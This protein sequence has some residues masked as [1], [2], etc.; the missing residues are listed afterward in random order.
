MIA[1]S[2]VPAAC[3]CSKTI[4]STASVSAPYPATA[5]ANGTA[6]L[7]CPGQPGS[8]N[9]GMLFDV[10]NTA[11]STVTLTNIS[12]L[13]PPAC[14]GGTA[15]CP[16]QIWYRRINLS[17]PYCTTPSGMF[18][19]G[20]IRDGAFSVTG[21]YNYGSYVT[22]SSGVSVPG[23]GLLGTAESSWTLLLTGSATAANAVV[24]V[25]GSFSLAIAPGET[26]GI[27]QIYT[28]LTKSTRVTDNYIPDYT[29]ATVSG[30]N[31]PA[32][33]FYTNGASGGFSDAN[34]RISAS[35][36]ATSFIKSNWANVRDTTVSF[37][38]TVGSGTTCSPPPVFYP[39]PTPPSPPSPNPPPSPP[40]PNP[41]TPPLPPSPPSPPPLPPSPPPPCGQRLAS[42]LTNNIPPGCPYGT[43]IPVTLVPG[44]KPS[45][46]TCQSQPTANGGF[47][48]DVTNLSP[49]NL[50]LTGMY[51]L[52]PSA[53]SVSGGVSNG[54]FPLSVSY[55]RKNVTACLPGLVCTGSVRDQAFFS[56]GTFATGGSATAVAPGAPSGNAYDP[57]WKSLINANLVN[58]FN[59]LTKVPVT[60]SLTLAP[61]EVVGLWMLFTDGTSWNRATDSSLPALGTYSASFN[62]LGDPTFAYT[63]GSDLR[64]SAGMQLTVCLLLSRLLCLPADSSLFLAVHCAAQLGQHAAS[65][66]R[67]QLQLEHPVLPSAAQPAPPPAPVPAPAGAA[68]PVAAASDAPAS[69]RAPIL[70]EEQGR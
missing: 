66:D 60:F 36:Q 2:P 28:D 25:A 22:A 50:T 37:G 1:S 47:A 26:V 54:R 70:A 20:G 30:F 59:V 16:V 65:H 53:Y 9:G 44:T 46:V 64:I 5:N 34:I 8:A 15:A 39:P 51:I 48:F 14:L 33:P 43:A 40:S 55:R 10:T 49:F 62:Q 38:Y 57:S 52:T 35:M 45:T 3:N 69:R 18:C 24:P 29:A 63:S 41:P 27:W 68:Q 32:D 31:T 67:L 61:G 12:I 11:S 17:A 13:T 7:A 4:C 58:G 42:S 19:N 23:A 56:N 21:V 6:T